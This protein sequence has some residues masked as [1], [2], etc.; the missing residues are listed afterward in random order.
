MEEQKKIENKQRFLASARA[1]ELV[2][3]GFPTE[4]TIELTTHCQLKCF[5]CPRESANK[6][7]MTK[8]N[9]DFRLF[10]KLAQEYVPYL[11]YLSLAGGLGEP[12]LYPRVVE[13]AAL[14]RELN[15][16]CL[17][18]VSTNALLPRSIELTEMLS[19]YLSFIQ[20]SIDGVGQQFNDIV[21]V[22]SMF[23]NFE[24]NVKGIIE[25]TKG[26][27]TDLRF[28]SVLHRENYLAAPQIVE[29][30]ADWGG[31][32]VYFNTFNLVSTLASEDEYQFY[33][34]EEYLQTVSSAVAY[35]KSMGI[36]AS[37]FD[38]REVKGFSYC[39]YPFNNF[40]IDWRG[41]LA[42]CCAKPFAAI[43]NFGSVVDQGIRACINSEKL[44]EI[45][46]KSNS[47]E[48]PSFCQ[49]C[50]LQYSMARVN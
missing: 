12:M 2:L 17:I 24:Q 18:S 31:R 22:P 16:T 4:L 1:R 15:S 36:K 7:L 9:M 34:S 46:R 38:M 43:L 32:E 13:A 41:I 47:N 42:P 40:Y 37:F 10:E 14:A 35:A 50:H 6:G 25:V 27:Q 48:T 29:T 21:G 39:A 8:G 5:T 30:L 45:R 19:K 49:R 11:D 44:V 26:T 33:L 20:I 3:D 23:D 28:N